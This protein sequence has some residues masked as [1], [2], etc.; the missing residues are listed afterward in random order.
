MTEIFATV[1]LLVLIGGLLM[2]ALMVLLSMPSS[3]LRELAL[4][5]VKWGV[6]ALSAIYIISPIDVFPD[7]I[8]GIGLM[9]DIAALAVC[10]ASAWSAVK[11]GK[12][13]KQLH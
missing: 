13:H 6:A 9:D 3:R 10:V 8:P 5:F 7:V 2:L 4:P 1:R 11:A 12:P